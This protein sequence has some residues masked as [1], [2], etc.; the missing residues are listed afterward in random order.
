MR[1]RSPHL[2]KEESSIQFRIWL[3]WILGRRDFILRQAAFF[4][5]EKS[6]CFGSAFREE[7]V[8]GSRLLQQQTQWVRMFHWASGACFSGKPSLTSVPG[9]TRLQ[10][11]PPAK[12]AKQLFALQP[13]PTVWFQD[14]QLLTEASRGR[15]PI[16]PWLLSEELGIEYLWWRSCFSKSIFKK[17]KKDLF[18][19]FSK[20]LWLLTVL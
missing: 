3:D 16:A 12:P 9:A 17:R 19:L 20:C 6:C 1:G 7:Q 2:P 8:R 11:W 13:C 15:Y 14:W 5:F 18:L 4:G 10:A